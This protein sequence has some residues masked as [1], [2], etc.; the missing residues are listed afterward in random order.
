MSLMDTVDVE[1]VKSTWSSR[2]WADLYPVATTNGPYVRHLLDQGAIIVGK[3]KTTQFAAGNEW[4]EFQL[5]MN[6]RG[7]RFQEPS[8]SSTGAAAS[9]A[10]Y[11][12]LD[13]AVGGDG[14]ILAPYSRL[15]LY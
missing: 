1:G 14:K 12:W 10:G 13:Y 3:T 8:G 15:K 6:P 5:P 7:D 11:S 2:A 9:L 4:I